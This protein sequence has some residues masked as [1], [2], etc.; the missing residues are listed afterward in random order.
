MRVTLV[1]GYFSGDWLMAML[2]SDFTNHPDDAADAF[3]D[4]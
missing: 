2:C 4:R 3:S 1:G